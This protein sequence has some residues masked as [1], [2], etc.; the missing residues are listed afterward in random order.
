MTRP[1]PIPT[2][3]GKTAKEFLKKIKEPPTEEQKAI[4]AEAD[5]VYSQIKRASSCENK[6]K[7]GIEHNV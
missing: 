6:T 2:I 7:Q 5:K 3:K 1:E 4:W